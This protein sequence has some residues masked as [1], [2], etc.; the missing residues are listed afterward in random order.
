M[1][2][3]G[4]RMRRGVVP[5]VIRTPSCKISDSPNVATM[6]SAARTATPV[7]SAIRNAAMVIPRI[8]HQLRMATDSGATTVRRSATKEVAARFVRHTG[9]KLIARPHPNN[10]FRRVPTAASRSAS[11]TAVLAVPVAARVAL[12]AKL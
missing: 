6:V 5:K 7:R 12:R 11:F 1:P 8:A 10:A 2:W 9:R 3:I 4:G